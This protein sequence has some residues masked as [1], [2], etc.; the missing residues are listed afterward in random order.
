MATDCMSG[1]DTIVENGKN[2]LLVE[3]GNEDEMAD[4]IQTLISDRKLRTL[5]G[6][7]ARRIKEDLS[8]DKLYKEYLDFI[9]V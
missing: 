9:R 2:G 3:P 1:K 7:A 6:S 4:A 8:A 5:L